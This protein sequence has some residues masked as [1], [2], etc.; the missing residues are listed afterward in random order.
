MEE[1]LGGVR[2]KLKPDA[3]AFVQPHSA[4]L[5]RVGPHDVRR[6]HAVA[7]A[8]WVQPAR[9]RLAQVL[10]VAHL[11]RKPGLGR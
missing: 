2:P 7:G 6:N 1:L 4:H 3:A 11:H 9:A 8:V 10:Q 5:R